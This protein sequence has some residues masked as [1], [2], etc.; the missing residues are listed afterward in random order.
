MLLKVSDV[1]QRLSLSAAKVYELVESRRISH[2]KIG[3]AIRFS[4]E[5]LAEFLE[6]TRRE[7][8]NGP[9]KTR[10]PRPRRRAAC[11]KAEWF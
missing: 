11:A 2:H 10:S 7:R 1:A 6:E 4:E 3:G 5:Q 9:V 8:G